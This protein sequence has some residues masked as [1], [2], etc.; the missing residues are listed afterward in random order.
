MKDKRKSQLSHDILLSSAVIHQL[1]ILGE[2]ANA[3]SKQTQKE[4]PN[5]PWKEIIGLRNRLI[6][7]YFDLDYN[8]IWQTIKEGLP[9]LVS[10][11]ASYLTETNN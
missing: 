9:P 6:H 3:V 11:I 7:E 4:L 1:E 5:I 10:E 2:A 8:I